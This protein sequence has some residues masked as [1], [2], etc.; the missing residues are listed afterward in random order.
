VVRARGSLDAIPT[1]LLITA[2]SG[3]DRLRVALNLCGIFAWRGRQERVPCRR[4]SCRTGEPSTARL[5]SRNTRERRHIMRFKSLN[6]STPLFTWH[7]FA[8]NIL[9]QFGSA[10]T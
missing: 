5:L 2:K 3:R 8:A 7:V 6:A 4:Y 9:Y 1:R 10:G